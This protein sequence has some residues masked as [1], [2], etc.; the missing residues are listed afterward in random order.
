M[1]RYLLKRFLLTLPALWLVLTLVFRMIHIVPGDPVE[2]MLVRARR[3]DN[4]LNC[5][6]YLGW[7][8][9]CTPSMDATCGN[10]GAAI[11]GIP[12]NFK[13]L[14]ARLFLN[15]TLPRFNLLSLRWLSALP[16]RFLQECLPRTGAARRPTALSKG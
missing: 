13:P 8:C 7:I 9:R 5:A 14:F 15:V 1:V 12:S 3:R 2:Q 16:L 6:M 4:W 10:S 11:L